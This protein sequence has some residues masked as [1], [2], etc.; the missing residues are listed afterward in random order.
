MKI[1]SDEALVVAFRWL[2]D[3]LK[4]E[5]QLPAWETYLES[6]PDEGATLYLFPSAWRLPGID[7]YVAFSVW[8]SN[9]SQGEAP[10]IQLYL[11][12]EERF[13]NRN[14][15]LSQIRQPLNGAGFTDRYEGEEDPDPRCPLWKYISVELS[16]QN[17]IGLARTLSAIVSGFRELMEVEAAVGE[18]FRLQPP[19]PPP[20]ERRLKTIAFLDT[21]WTGKEPARRM[22]ELAIISVA[23]D[24]ISDE[25]LGIL[26]EYVMR[27]G[28][29][30]DKIKARSLLEKAHRIVAHN[31]GSDQSLLDRQLPDI[32]KNKW[33]CSFRGVEWKRLMGVQSASQS[34]LM[35]RAGLRYEQDH[36][37]RA[38]ADDLKRLLAQKHEGGRTYLGRLLDGEAQKTL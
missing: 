1:L 29:R 22:T 20:C 31:C 34:S 38:D 7:D 13:P 17:G 25:V 8:W 21:E 15:L 36:H 3:H 28:K 14:Q 32:E 37:A 10:C 16:G 19:P 23:Y 30:L 33:L 35:G 24:P 12:A 9:D 2:G 18:I 26:D 6:F 4:C 5:L 11:P 27:K